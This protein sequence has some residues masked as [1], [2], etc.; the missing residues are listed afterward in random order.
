M[1]RRA[2]LSAG[3][4]ESP[5]AFYFNIELKAGEMWVAN[6]EQLL[7]INKMLA[8]IF[9]WTDSGETSPET[10]PPEFD[11]RVNGERKYWGFYYDSVGDYNK[12]V[13]V[14]ISFITPIGSWVAA[15]T[16]IPNNPNLD[17]F[18]IFPV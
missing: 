3:K 14:Y 16:V 5:Y 9:T 11:L 7:E 8:I 6:A 2:L 15:V 12:E 4:E 10:I 18:E 1:R 13:D 17:S